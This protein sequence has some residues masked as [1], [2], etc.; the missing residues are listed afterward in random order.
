MYYLGGNLCNFSIYCVFETIGLHFCPRTYGNL[1]EL[2][3]F[4]HAGANACI[5]TKMMEIC[6]TVDFHAKHCFLVES[7]RIYI[8]YWFLVESTQP[9]TLIFLRKYWCFH[10]GGVQMLGITGISVNSAQF[11]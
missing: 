5:I 10:P 4:L 6:K 3:L 11:D 1:L 7:H 9:G 2:L 8:N